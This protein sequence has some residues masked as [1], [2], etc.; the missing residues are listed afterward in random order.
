MRKHNVMLVCD[1]KDFN[2]NIFYIYFHVWKKGAEHI[3]IK[4]VF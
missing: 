2:E 4:V 3:Y 1:K